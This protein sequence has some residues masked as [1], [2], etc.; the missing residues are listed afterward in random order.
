MQREH[1]GDEQLGTT[2]PTQQQLQQQWEADLECAEQGGAQVA[3]LVGGGSLQSRHGGKEAWGHLQ[4]HAVCTLVH[5]SRACYIGSGLR[6][7]LR[8]WH[9][10]FG[11]VSTMACLSKSLRTQR[12]WS[13][14]VP[15]CWEQVLAG[16]AASSCGV[17]AAKPWQAACPAT[18]C[19]RKPEHW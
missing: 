7:I 9:S 17:S 3:R 6:E 5:W 12:T 18:N 10:S 11:T 4:E 1:C 14:S 13:H 16:L 19:S 15:L 2:T 8:I